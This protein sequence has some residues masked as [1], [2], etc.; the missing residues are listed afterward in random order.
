MKFI[1]EQAKIPQQLDLLNDINS[2]AERLSIKLGNLNPDSLNISDYNRRYFF[3]KLKNLKHEMQFSSYL[4]AWS[5]IDSKVEYKKF[6]FLEYGAG[7]GLTSLLANE[8]GLNVIYNDIYE[9]STN[10]AKVI[11]KSLRNEALYYLTG[12]LDYTIAFLKS[13]N[14]ECNSVT[15]SDVIEHIY[16]IKSFFSKLPQLG[17]NSLSIVMCS[18]ANPF[19]PYIRRQLIK[20]QVKHEYY[21]RKM[22]YGHKE[23]DSLKAYRKTRA[24]IIDSYLAKNSLELKK[25]EVLKLLETTRGMNFI[26]IQKA[27]DKYNKFQKFPSPQQYPTNTCDPLTGNWCEHLMNPFELAKIVSASG[28]ASSV[29][30]GYYGN[31][32]GFAKRFIGKLLD[33]IISSNILGRKSLVLAP[34]YTIY[35]KNKLM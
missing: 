14:V 7:S 1:Y 18:G 4:L 10:D 23:R 26:D 34:F 27:I 16:D 12:D 15:S 33:Q 13:N 11:A 6:Y 2:A 20:K 9:I 28:I 5:L 31:F 22:D 21:D 32:P 19:H 24:E 17:S 30:P 8:L 25:D 29:Y 3:N 35:G